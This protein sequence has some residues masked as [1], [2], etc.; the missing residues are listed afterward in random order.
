ME[1]VSDKITCSFFGFAAVV[2][3][4][5]KTDSGF[6]VWV[7][8]SLYVL[9]TNPSGTPHRNLW[10]NLSSE[11]HLSRKYNYF[12]SAHNDCDWSVQ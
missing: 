6:C 4:V 12:D 10:H 5:M 3:A 1:G 8:Y 2:V 11:M 7:K 9:S